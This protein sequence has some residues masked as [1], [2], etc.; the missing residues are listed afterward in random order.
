MEKMFRIDSE[1]AIRNVFLN[2]TD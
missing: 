1:G 2:G